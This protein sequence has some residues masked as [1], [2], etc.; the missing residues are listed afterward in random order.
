[1]DLSPSSSSGIEHVEIFYAAANDANPPQY[2]TEEAAGADIAA[3]LDA[4]IVIKPGCRALIPTGISLE[5]PAGYEVQL[6]PRSG[7]AL[8]HGVTVLNTPGT[9]DSDYRG[10]LKVL[11]ANFGEKPFTVRD[12]DRIG[13][14]VVHQ[15]FKAVFKKK[16]VLSKTK[17]GS[18][19]YG[20]TGV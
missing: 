15:V 2:K 5:I 12:G 6:R 17:R 3:K 4:S 16:E 11:L 8:E 13:Q 7:L 19:G 10:E 14:L 18:A 20:S 1:M 9:I